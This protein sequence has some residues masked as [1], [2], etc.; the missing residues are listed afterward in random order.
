MDKVRSTAISHLNCRKNTSTIHAEAF[1]AA[2]F[3]LDVRVAKLEG[4]VQAFLD[5]V[6]LGAVDEP[7]A[8]VVDDDLD[9]RVVEDDVV[10]VDGVGVVDNVSV[11]GA[12]RA[13]HAQTEAD[14]MTA[15]L[16]VIPDPRC[17]GCRQ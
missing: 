15:F 13:P 8:F 14:A 5:E 7:E 3:T 11:A 10:V 2:A 1:A 12:A 9:A 6:D 16:Q 4:L 17:R